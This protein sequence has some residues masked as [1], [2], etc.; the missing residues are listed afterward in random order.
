MAPP[1]LHLKDIRLSF[2]G[3]PL[4][5]GAE[6][7]VGEGARICLVG[8]NGSGKSTLLKIAAGVLA[9]DDGEIFRQPGK[10]VAYLAQE[11]DLSAFKTT[12]E[13]AEADLV[14][15]GEAYR[16]RQLLEDLGLNGAEDPA[17]LS[18]GEARR[19]A[20]ARILAPRP[21]I[22]L[23]DEPTNH[24]D[25]SAIEWL[26][27]ELKSLRSAL[28]LVSHDRRVLETLSTETVWLFNGVSRRLA[29]GFKY[30][31]P[32]RDKLAEEQA[33]EEKRQDK[34]LQR[35][36]QW[37]AKGVTARRK[38]NQGRLRALKKLRAE[39]REASGPSAARA[40]TAAAGGQ[41]GKRVLELTAAAFAYDPS[42]PVVTD[43]SLRVLRGD[44]LGVVG[45][46]GAGKTTLLKLL[47]GDLPPI[48]GAAHQGAG[49]AVAR[50][51]Q[52][53][54]ALK[55]DWTL[56]EALTQG[57]GDTVEINGQ[58][59]HVMG[60]LQDFQFTPAQIRTPVA[61][62][63]GGE[64]GRLA[65]ARILSLPSNL[66]VLD[67]P[68]NDLDLETLDLLQEIIADYAG[69]VILVSHDRDF[70]DR[71][72]TSTLASEGAGRWI[73]Y[74]GGYSDMLAQRAAGAADALSTPT[75]TKAEKP[76]ASGTGNQKPA[77]KKRL[78]PKQQHALKILPAE[79]ERHSARI[80]KLEAV[81]ADPDLYRRD[82]SLFQKTANDLDSARAALDALETEWLE[83]EILQDEIAAQA[84]G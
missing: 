79:I 37:L 78:S 83:I 8:R 43:L 60:Y 77:P 6:L 84:K 63:S 26:E 7:A 59:R 20:L 19:C 70:L 13:A 67:E 61:A 69:T 48:D 51:D 52:T 4:L 45:P 11:P 29:H 42:A 36:L 3:E 2:G 17:T 34:L 72:V 73:E 40:M 31:E 53:R 9:P 25:L 5:Q 82:P 75:K 15:P 55:P 44:R 54:E 47:L 38:R 24:L 71:T 22:L 23:L 50:L 10:T 28:V 39:R 57:T 76:K 81:I 49:L 74:A 18:G 41:S 62:L 21:D 27:G 30:F 16:A 56:A 64:R 14:D 1:I 58:K 66:L 33:Q 68:T 12:L 35:E 80:E 32:W 65:L 46:N